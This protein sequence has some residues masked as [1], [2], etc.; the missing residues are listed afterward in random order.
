MISMDMILYSVNSQK[1]RCGYTFECE[2][3][4]TK[5]IIALPNEKSIFL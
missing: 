1:G 3:E 4:V 5:R 2:S